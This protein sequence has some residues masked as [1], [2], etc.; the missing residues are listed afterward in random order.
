MSC[1]VLY[2]AYRCQALTVSFDHSRFGNYLLIIFLFSK[3][4][5]I[6][7][8]IGQLFMLN[9]VLSMKYSSFGIDIAKMMARHKDWTEDSY[10]AFP[11]VTLCDFKVRGEDMANT[12]RYTLQCVLPVNLYNEKIFLFQWYWMILVGS[13][14]VLS[15]I[16]WALRAVFVIDRKRFIRN[17]I[18]S[19]VEWRKKPVRI[20]NT[21]NENHVNAAAEVDT[22]QD[23]RSKNKTNKDKKANKE[24]TTLMEEETKKKEQEEQ[25]DL[26]TT[27]YLRQ[28]G[29]FLLRLIAHNTDNITTTDVTFSLWEQW[30]ERE[31]NK[32]DKANDDSEED[33]INSDNSVF[34]N[35][36]P[37]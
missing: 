24:N 34:E 27:K 4:C 26:F 12:F 35:S 17:H 19:A 9:Y 18:N 32:K 5:Y 22:V 11:R 29:A 21:I 36:S 20:D 25:M 15:F 37:S 3:L 1:Q 33:R 28:D 31:K 8:C 7:N 14:S 16:V 2:I 6:G 13:L 23:K 30:K 10:V